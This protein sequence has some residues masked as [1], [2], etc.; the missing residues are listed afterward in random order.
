MSDLDIPQIR[1]FNCCIFTWKLPPILPPLFSTYF[2]M[3]CNS[4]VY[5]LDLS[6]NFVEQRN[7]ILGRV[8]MTK[9]ILAFP[10]AHILSLWPMNSLL[11]PALLT[12]SVL[13][14]DA[15]SV[16]IVPMLHR[17]RYD[18]DAVKSFPVCGWTDA[19]SFLGA[20]TIRR[21]VM[22]SVKSSTIIL[23]RLFELPCKFVSQA[24]WTKGINVND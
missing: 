18:D 14:W 3:S 21:Y 5:A 7:N 15:C 19:N 11:K 8:K 2:I 6:S 17:W 24:G 4:V 23:C 20:I 9:V 13:K 22:L 12:T 1:S 10:L 16:G